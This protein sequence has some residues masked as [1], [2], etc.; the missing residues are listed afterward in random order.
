MVRRS[1][2]PESRRNSELQRPSS[3]VLPT[4]HGFRDHTLIPCGAVAE[5]SLKTPYTPHAPGLII[6]PFLRL[7]SDDP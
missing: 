6:R 4:F 2:L 3:A 5:D 7:L 1:D